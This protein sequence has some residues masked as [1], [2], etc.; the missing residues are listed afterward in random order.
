MA[1]GDSAMVCVGG[2]GLTAGSLHGYTRKLRKNY[3][4]D[5]A[6][7]ILFSYHYQH[8]QFRI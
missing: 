2:G 1:A 3:C 6:G 5:F 7:K 4:G 8:D